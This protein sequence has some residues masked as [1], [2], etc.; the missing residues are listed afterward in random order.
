MQDSLL[1]YVHEPLDIYIYV[2]VFY[3]TPFSF[4]Y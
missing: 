4:N 1:P 2:Y 3:L